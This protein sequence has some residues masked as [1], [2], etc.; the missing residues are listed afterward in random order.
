MSGKYSKKKTRRVTLRGILLT[1]IAALL[2]ICILM[3]LILQKMDP[4]PSGEQ[5][6][7]ETS[8]ENTETAG[9]A[10]TPETAPARLDELEP[11]SINLGSGMRITDVGK[12]TGVYMEDGTDEI[13]SGVMMITVTNEGET[14]V[15]YAEISVPVGDNTAKFT[16]S[17]LPAGST[18][19]LL[20]QT[21]MEYVP[22]TY[23]TAIAENVVLFSE[24]LSL[25][26]DRV[27]IG[28]LNGAVNVTNISGEDITG[29]IVIYYKNSAADVYYGGI[30]YRIRVEGG[31][32][33]DEI[34]Q[35]MGSHL[36]ESGST[37]MFVTCGAG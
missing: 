26:E 8:A 6:T 14:A 22:E 15:Q 10:G 36:S 30:T 34:R 35:V 16:L 31:L 13:V 28:I 5:T 25:C 12:Y 11:V 20:E 21:R 18:V 32:K 27:K 9:P 29:D 2:V 23:T 4:K 3:T 37:V 7:G 17:T 24:P 1:I 33:A 19:V